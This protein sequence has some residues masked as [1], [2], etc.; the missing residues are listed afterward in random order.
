MFVFFGNFPRQEEDPEP[1]L[2]A[3]RH[4]SLRFH[5][6]DTVKMKTFELIQN[7]KIEGRQQHL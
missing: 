4:F 2:S 7:N 5:H 3:L 6:M 1:E